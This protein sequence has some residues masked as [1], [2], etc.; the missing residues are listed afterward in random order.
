MLGTGGLLFYLTIILPSRGPVLGSKE[1]LT[2]S[3][4]YL[5]SIQS[6]LL[7]FASRL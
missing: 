5:P 4:W 3:I 1:E 7:S 2:I 6:R